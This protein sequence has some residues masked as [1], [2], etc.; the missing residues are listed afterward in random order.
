MK[1]SATWIPDNCRD[2]YVYL[3]VARLKYFNILSKRLVPIVVHAT[4]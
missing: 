1:D 3:V 2:Y 4:P